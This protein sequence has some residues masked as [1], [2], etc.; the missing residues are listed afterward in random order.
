MTPSASFQEPL[1]NSQS[2]LISL[3][4][5]SS[6]KRVS[7]AIL[8]DV[9]SKERK[10]LAAKNNSIKHLLNILTPFLGGEHE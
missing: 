6:E 3:S 8:A 10:K 5:K 9:E 4:S 2:E 1:T 7:N